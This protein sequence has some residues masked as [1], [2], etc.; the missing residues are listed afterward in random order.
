VAKGSRLS[1][2]SPTRTCSPI[3]EEENAY[4]EKVIAPHKP[5]SDRLFKE[6]RGRIKEDESTVPQK[7]GDWLYWT[8]FE[9]GGE[10]PRWWRKPV[11][12]ARTS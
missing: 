8:D 12:A 11:A 9:T 3:S 7:D 10:Y 2:K 4:F 5:L 6:M 1:R